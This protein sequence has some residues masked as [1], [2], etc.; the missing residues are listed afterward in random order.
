MLKISFSFYEISVQNTGLDFGNEQYKALDSQSGAGYDFSQEMTSSGNSDQLNRDKL[1][2]DHTEA[3]S[4]VYH[5][6]RYPQRLPTA[7]MDSNSKI[8]SAKQQRR[9]LRQKKREEEMMER[10]QAQ[11]KLRRFSST[12]NDESNDDFSGSDNFSSDDEAEAIV[13][14][15]QVSKK[16]YL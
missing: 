12:S 8:P 14:S 9:K 16:T 15:R 11:R 5:G 3:R 2:H 7:A 4:H 10:N 1:S 6:Y 13:P